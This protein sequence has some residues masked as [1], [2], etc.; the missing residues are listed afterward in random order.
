LVESFIERWN[1]T[2]A[3]AAKGIY[4]KADVPPG[5]S[6]NFIPLSIYRDVWQSMEESVK[7]AAGVESLDLLQSE[8]FSFLEQL[9]SAARDVETELEKE[10]AGV[11]V[12]VRVKIE[13][14]LSLTRVGFLGELQVTNDGDQPMTNITVTLRVTEFGDDKKTNVIDRFVI[15]DPD[16]IFE[17]GTN[18]SGIIAAKSSGDA[19]WLIMALREAAPNATRRYNIGGLLTYVV[20]GGTFTMNLY[21]DTITVLPDP[22]LHVKYFWEQQIYAD[23]RPSPASGPVV[24]CLLLLGLFMCVY[25]WISECIPFPAVPCFLIKMLFLSPQTRTH[26][27][28]HYHTLSHY[29]TITHTF[30]LGS[31]HARERTLCPLLV[32][33]DVPQL[34]LRHGQS[35]FHRFF[36]T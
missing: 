25:V 19:K 3:Y 9:K 14:E 11:C 18:G 36:A 23:V 13:Q 29:H 1:N 2:H 12:K 24:F 16:P 6:T 4:E 28:T 30:F 20:G 7:Q 10:E 5:A 27:H 34:W 31:F 21:P 35:S 17:G 15:G 33:R 8:G 26:T 22:R 32:S